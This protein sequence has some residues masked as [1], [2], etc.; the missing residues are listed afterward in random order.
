MPITGAA[1]AAARARR[2]AAKSA[3]LEQVAEH[4]ARL[5]QQEEDRIQ[6]ELL[7]MEALRVA[8]LIQR[9]D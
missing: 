3:S 1:D 7:K 9:G 6:E 4:G 5:R 2:G 8:E